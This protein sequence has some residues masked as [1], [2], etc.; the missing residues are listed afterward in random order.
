MSSNRFFPKVSIVINCLNGSEFLAE[1]L[2]SI[3]S[4]SF[5]DWEIIFWDNS[6]TDNSADILVDYD[7]RIKYYKS[8]FTMPLYTARNC[9]IEKCTGSVICFLDCDD[10]WHVDKLLL[11]VKEYEK[12]FDFVY[13]LFVD[14]DSS[15]CIT[16]MSIN[17]HPKFPFTRQLLIHNIVSIGSVLIDSTLLKS[18]LF[19]PSYEL[20]GDFDLWVRLSFFANVKFIPT[21]L[22]YSRQH[23]SNL[24]NA[25]KHLWISER[26]S[27]YLSFLKHHSPFSF[28]EIILYIIRAELKGL[29]NL[30]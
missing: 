4:Q 2:N 5:T 16:P 30:R 22:E 19:N 17:R 11:Q 1:A 24:S 10:F 23:R 3:Y 28:P 12:G 26:R 20:I 21:V 15:S 7:S 29:L 27:F 8:E 25:K 18:H 9:A 6:S 13:S 14:V